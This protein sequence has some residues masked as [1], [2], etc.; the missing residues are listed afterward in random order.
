MEREEKGIGLEQSRRG[1]TLKIR[2]LHRGERRSRTETNR[3]KFKLRK[4]TGTPELMKEAVVSR[5]GGV[6]TK[7]REEEKGV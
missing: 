1:S 5:R 4:N 3:V 6:K 2:F 7:T